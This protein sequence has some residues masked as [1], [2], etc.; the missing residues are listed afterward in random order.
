MAEPKTKVTD[1]SVE[2][3][4]S[5]VDG[6]TKRKDSFVLLELFKDITGE[7]PRMWGSSMVG[8]GSYHY[9]SERSSQKATGS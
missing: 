7:E 3:F 1:A 8:F 9:K 2:G 6:E 5:S 4:L